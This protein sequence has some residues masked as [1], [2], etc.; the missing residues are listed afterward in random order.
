MDTRFWGPSGWKLLHLMSFAY[1]PKTD[2]AA[3]KEFI[4]TLPY[5]LP[6]K[7]CRTSLIQYYEELPFEDA[8]ESAAAFSRWMWKIH[9]KVNEK[10]R[11]Q[12]QTIPP[13][14]SY[15][16]VKKVYLDRL[17]YGCSKTDFPG[18]EFLFSIV[19]NHPFNKGERSS[20]ISGA[21]P[22]EDIDPKDEETLLRWNY[23]TPER[24][25]PYLCRLWQTLPSVLPFS[26]WRSAWK[27]KGQAFCPRVWSSRQESLQELWKIRCSIEHELELINRTNFQELCSDLRL[28]R[29]ACSK[30]RSSRTRTCRRKR[31]RFGFGSRYAK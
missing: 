15:A 24:R 2:K 5:V 16:N 30:S 1:N 21:P 7:F 12:G 27:T 14:P 22:L 26:E 25:Y 11:S 17:S 23:L 18:W 8:L 3:M 4:T 9:G 29:S 10:L 19:E 31:R 28:H 13:D 20:P 6:C